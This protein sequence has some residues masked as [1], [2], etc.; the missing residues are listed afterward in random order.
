MNF[1]NNHVKL[2]TTAFL[3]FVLLTLMVAIFPAL[4]NQANNAPLPSAIPLSEEAV[5]GK[6][7]FI[8]NGCVA[9][10]TQQVRSVEM[11]RIWGSRPGVAADYASNLRISTLVNTATLMGTERTGPDLTDVGNRQPSRDWHLLHLY[12]PR[13]VV[14][15]SIMPSYAWLFQEVDRVAK[16]QIEI[17]LPDRF[18]NASGKRVIATPDALNLIAYLQSLRQASLETANTPEFLY[19]TTELT[20]KTKNMEALQG[21]ILYATNCQSCHQSNGEGLKG[22]FPPL[23]GSK[24]V[25]DDNFELFIDI[26]MNGY[27]A[28]EE[29]G[30]MPAIGRNMKFTT[31]EITAL[32][33]HERNSWGNNARQISESEI[34]KILKSLANKTPINP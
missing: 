25:L 32:A 12:N 16:S 7:L 30:V 33:N 31:K 3:L 10:H 8:S 2:F 21:K 14:P 17:N 1:F 9:C 22:A 4:N 27:D 28:R 11:D 6:A 23:K 24:I 20:K 5:K 13:A 18:K 15:Q 34:E 26:I 29:Y 19:A